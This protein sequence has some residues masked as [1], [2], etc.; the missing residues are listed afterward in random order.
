[1]NCFEI[2]PGERKK[3]EFNLIERIKNILSENYEFS[4]DKLMYKNIKKNVLNKILELNEFEFNAEILKFV[5]IKKRKINVDDDENNNNNY[6][7]K[8]K[9]IKFG[10]DDKMKNKL[11]NIKKELV[12]IIGK[13]A[14]IINF[15]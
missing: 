7:Y 10:K 15:D 3:T 1:M 8:L 2:F 14:E 11:D 9:I 4:I 13:Q 12:N 6:K 5:L